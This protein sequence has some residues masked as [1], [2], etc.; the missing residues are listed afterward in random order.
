[1]PYASNKQ[2]AFMHIHHPEI[3]AKWHEEGHGYV[4]GGKHDPARKKRRRVRKSQTGVSKM[5]SGWLKPLAVGTAGGALANQLPSYEEQRRLRENRRRRKEYRAK[6]KKNGTVAPIDAPQWPDDG[7]F[8]AKAAQEAYD[9]VMKMDRDSAEAFT[10]MVVSDALEADLEANRRTLQAHLDEV[11]AKRFADLKRATMR[12]VSKGEE[13]LEFAQALAVLE[14]I[15]KADDDPWDPRAHPRGGRNP[16]WFRSAVSHTQTKPLHTK[17]ATSI[18]IRTHPQHNK[19]SAAEQARYQDEYRQLSSFLGAV[20]QAGANPGDTRVKLHF[21]DHD[22]TEYSE[23]HTA[24]SVPRRRSLDPRERS[25]IGMSAEPRDVTVG[26]A[27]FGLTQALGGDL[28]STAMGAMNRAGAGMPRFADAWTRD[29]GQQNTNARLYGRMEAGGKYLAQVAPRGSKAE[30]AGHFGR[31]VGQYGPQAETVIGPPTRRTAYRYRGTEKK[32]DPAMVAAYETTVKHAMS[33]RGMS[34]DRQKQIKTAQNR[35]LSARVKQVA[36]ETKT[37]EEA[38]RL[39][40]E[41]RQAIMNAAA[42]E[43]GGQVGVPNRE[44]QKAGTAAIATYLNTPKERGGAAPRRGLY[45]LQL[46]SGNTPPSEGVILDRDGQIVTQAIGYG[47]DHYLPFN[48]KNLSKLKGGSYIRNRSVGGLTSEDIYTGLISGA[49]SVTVVS[50][51]GTFTMEFEPDFRGARRH[52]DKA[53]RMTR[54]Y[55]QLLDAVQSEQVDREDIDPDVRRAITMQV[56]REAEQYGGLSSAQTRT[57]IERKIDEYKSNPDWD[58]QA[59]AYLDLKTNFHTA[60]MPEG[61]EKERIRASMRNQMAAEKEYKFRLNGMG[62]ADALESLREQFPYYIKTDYQPTR[63]QE[64]VETERDQG[65]VEPGKIRPTAAAAGLFG[66]AK[67]GKYVGSGGKISARDADYAG[68]GQIERLVREVEGRQ[69]QMEAEGKL[70][71]KPGE[72]ESAEPGKSPATT[73]GAETTAATPPAAPDPVARAAYTDKAVALQQALKERSTF[74]ANAPA[75]GNMNEEQFRSHLGD[76]ENL[77]KFDEWVTSH[78]HLYENDRVV[79]AVIGGYHQASG[80]VGQKA[81]EPALNQQWGPKPY[82]FEGKA[83]TADATAKQREGELKRIGTGTRVGLVNLKPLGQ[84]TDDE[85]RQEMDAVAQIRLKVA[86]L[87]GEPTLEDKKA[88]F[89]GINL[90]SPSVEFA[91]KDAASMDN[92]LEGVHRTRAINQGVPD[93]ERG[94]FDEVHHNPI[95]EEKNTVKPVQ[96]KVARL[97][98]LTDRTMKHHAVDTPEYAQLEALHNDLTDFGDAIASP[99]EFSALPDVHPEAHHLIMRAIREGRIVEMAPPAEK[100]KV[101]EQKPR[102]GPILS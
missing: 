57:E 14:Q 65:Y 96:E 5:D 75:W 16:G 67:T 40:K 94:A 11:V 48:L 46:A 76:K 68:L 1:M 15:S 24:G 3:A 29:Y 61:P 102:S 28:S 83:Y 45:N 42:K 95:T 4:K 93:K 79:Q 52:N 69:R 51:S 19:M 84:M 36:D 47:D 59:D 7:F 81:Y 99:E 100:S 6:V 43:V 72:A 26:G 23:E 63:E 55:E 30:L 25:L 97:L 38:V 44:E 86:S 70:E 50:R 64:R 8:N 85:L 2:A 92:Y 49:R 60:G 41:E 12:A 58:E 37:P 91:L 17:T 53:A 87:E 10:T 66:N 74:G 34:E 73:A 35:A 32:P 9:L 77:R 80:R 27:A 21:R 90:D 54:R 101:I 33:R 71:E 56:K 13:G 20:H 82:W 78:E 31:F 89:K 22:G 18:G 98:D 39:P 88:M 62:Y